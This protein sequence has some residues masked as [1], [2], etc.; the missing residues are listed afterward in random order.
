MRAAAS[1]ALLVLA[2][3]V[4]S[5]GDTLAVRRDGRWVE[6]YR[7]TQ[8]PAT[9]ARADRTILDAITWH[10]AAAR[11]QRGELSLAGNGLAW[12]V[13]VILARFDP[14]DLWLDVA[15]TPDPFG[16]PDRWQVDDAAASAVVALNAGQFTGAGPWGWIV[17]DG[18]ERQP[19]GH[20]PLA[21]AVVQDSSGAMHFVSPDEIAAVRRRGGIRTAVQSFPGVLLDDGKVPEA[22]QHEGRGINRHHRDARVAL[23]VLRDGRW[24]AMLTRFEGLGGVLASLPFGLSTPEMAALSGALG[25]VRAVLLDGGMSGQLMVRDANGDA[26]RWNGLRKVPAGLTLTPR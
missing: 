25:C 17:Q 4:Q 16:R 24:L 14:A 1:L 5:T 11:V 12:R 7:A 18:I 10:D 15:W 8:A 19:P 21:P 22:L 3:P 13:R 26:R 9:W 2:G 20:G 23:C 6:W